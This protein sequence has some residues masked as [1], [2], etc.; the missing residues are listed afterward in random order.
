MQHVLPLQA[1]GPGKTAK[2]K[3]KKKTNKEK[4]SFQARLDPYNA[5]VCMAHL[6]GFRS[7]DGKQTVRH[8]QKR[9][10]EKKKKKRERKYVC[11]A[12]HKTC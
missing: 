1:I 10:Q 3:K 8:E 12:I 6:R 9:K 5:E 4:D 2:K 11:L 7:Y